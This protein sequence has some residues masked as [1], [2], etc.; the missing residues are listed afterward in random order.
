MAKGKY[1]SYQL[2]RNVLAAFALGLSFC[3]ILDAR[4]SDL[5]EAWYGIMRCVKA[6]EIRTRCQVLTWQELS[7]RLPRVLQHFLM[8]KYGLTPPRFQ[9]FPKIGLTRTRG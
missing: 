4:R 3:V 7:Q 9:E 8:G 2:I 5:I 1:A 6:S